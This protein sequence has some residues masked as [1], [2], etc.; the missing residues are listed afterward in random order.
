MLHGLCFGEEAGARNFVFF[1]VNW[2][3]AAMKGTSCVRRVRLR[4]VCLFFCRIVMVASSCFGCACAWVLLCVG[5]YKGV[6]ESVV[7]DRLGMAA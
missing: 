3:Q 6:L 5:T 2:L 1:R 4:S 7:A